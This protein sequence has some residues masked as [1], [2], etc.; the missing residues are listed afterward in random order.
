[1]NEA[2]RMPGPDGGVFQGLGQEAL[3]HSG[4]SHQQDVLVL[5][6]ELQGEDGV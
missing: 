4:G 2:D 6:Q 1:M 3:A 5:V